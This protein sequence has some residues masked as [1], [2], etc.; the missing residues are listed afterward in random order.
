MKETHALSRLLA[1]AALAVTLSAQAQPVYIG[2]DAELGYAGSTSAEAIRQGILIAAE[3]INRSGGVLGGRR[4]ELVER[5]NDSVPARGIENIK[6]LAA[7]PDLVAVFCGRFSPPV[8]EALPTLHQLALPLLNPWAATDSIVDNGYQ[9]N[10]VFR[11]SLS[12]S[13]GLPTMLHHAQAKGARRVGLLLLNSSWGRGGLKAAE[14]YVAKH[15]GLKIV[16]TRWFNQTDKS[17]RD[18][19][20][21]LVDAGAQAVLLVANNDVAAKVKELAQLPADRRVPL[22]S[23]WGV[24]GG[25]FPEEAGF[26]ALQA[27]DFSVVQTYS[28]LGAKRPQ[29]RR[30]LAAAQRLFGVVD[31][32]RLPSPVGV[33]HA[34]ELTHIL[35]LAI[36]RAGSTD[37][38]AIRNAL[39]QVKNYDGLI[40]TYRQP[41]SPT[42]HDALGP[43]DVF[44][45]RY[46]ADG[47]LE[48]LP[49]P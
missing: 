3:E 40:K 39:E 16:D 10:F 18:H 28:F 30:V 29:A 35:A 12:D 9:P 7:L 2:L 26:A 1:G 44:M 5:A 17:F 47:A 23:H 37:R 20:L 34:Y 42:R 22:V 8:L 36:N 43:E 24:T 46:A 48:R 11:L 21:A 4:L 38:R 15:P 19:Y 14:A 31:S 41:F 32:R 25:R 33:A 27:L 49:R 45:A 13:W 6:E